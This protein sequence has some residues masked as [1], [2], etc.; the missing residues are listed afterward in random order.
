MSATHATRSMSVTDSDVSDGSDPCGSTSLAYTD[1]MVTSKPALSCAKSSGRVVVNLLD[2]T[3]FPDVCRTLSCDYCL[4]RQARR[5]ALAITLAKPTR[6][7]RLSLVAQQDSVSPSRTALI[8]IKRIRQALQ[9]MEVNPGEWSYTIEPNPGGTGY[10]A[11]CLQRGPYVSQDLLQEACEKARAGIPYIN[12]IKRTGKW[13]SLY[14]L[15]GYGADGYGLKA[16]R[17]KGS[18]TLALKLNNGHLEH[19]TRAF[20]EYDGELLGVRDYERLAIATM[21]QDQPIAL[22]G[23]RPEQVERVL[24]NRQLTHRMI[25]DVNRRSADRLRI[26]R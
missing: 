7:I 4:P 10:H 20:Y 14:S 23:M 15:K 25:L 26:M 16:F 12:A 9:R 2:G 24:S 8:R 11:H 3:V 19:H 18:A 6:M 1:Q 21:N 5:R 22:V 13:T 17:A